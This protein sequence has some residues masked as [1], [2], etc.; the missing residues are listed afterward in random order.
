MADRGKAATGRGQDDGGET[1]SG[2]STAT[3]LARLR[4][5]NERLRN[6]AHQAWQ[7]LDMVKDE[8]LFIA[9]PE[10]GEPG[11][12]DSGNEVAYMNRRGRELMT[13]YRD[14]VAERYGF[15]TLDLAGTSIHAFHANPDRI[16]R[17]LSGLRPGQEN[18][19]AYI[20]IG[21]YTVESFTRVLTNLDGSEAGY[22]A[23]WKDATERLH[24]EHT[25]GALKGLV[26]F[27]RQIVNEVEPD[28]VTDMLA[29]TLARNFDLDR[30]VVSTIEDG[31]VHLGA[32]YSR[33]GEA[34]TG[35]S[36]DF[37]TG[38]CKALRAN[39]EFRVADVTAD[40]CCPYQSVVQQQG[41]Y[42]CLPLVSG[43]THLGFIHMS[44]P[45]AAY[46]TDERLE[47]IN[48]YVEVTAPVI[49]S[50]RM[51]AANKAMS[52]T[53][54]LTEL[55]N[56]RFLEETL[57]FLEEQAR[58]RQTPISL[59]LADL[60]GF[61]SFNDGLGHKAGDQALQ[62]FGHLLRDSTRNS[63]LC[64]RYGGEEFVV[65][66]P[67]T[68]REETAQVAE[69]IRQ[70]T[71]ATPLAR[72]REHGAVH[73]TVSLGMATFPADCAVSCDLIRMADRALYAAKAAG[74]NQ[75]MAFA[76]LGVTPEDA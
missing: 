26:N 12:H 28:E 47:L 39:H 18:R 71:A 73:R 50:I 15:D 58:R 72:D 61:K 21:P 9:A 20:H 44:S 36:R 59:I 3:E 2:E 54:P 7:M 56:R 29:R 22:V 67:E 55:Y 1:A 16:R 51:V 23:V 33:H 10:P 63:D 66:L 32:A 64:A 38:C 46:F 53:D 49:N 4:A 62:V 37:D 24:L 34:L 13:R 6:E 17:L 69:R 5:E 14:E 42:L 19:N 70:A 52:L 48:G 8:A 65:L 75:A 45:Q 68:D 76:E 35:Y 57:P 11:S 41:S 43:G 27:A 31:Q 60:D 74:R 25:V 30:I 40:H